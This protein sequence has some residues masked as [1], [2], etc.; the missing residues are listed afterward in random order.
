MSDSSFRPFFAHRLF[1]VAPVAV[2]KCHFNALYVS[3]LLNDQHEGPRKIQEDL[4]LPL[5]LIFLNLKL[6]QLH[7]LASWITEAQA[8]IC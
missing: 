1:T 4:K 5:V 6:Y 7:A 8:F 3:H 2:E